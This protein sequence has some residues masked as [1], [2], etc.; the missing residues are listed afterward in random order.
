MVAVPTEHRNADNI[1]SI[2]SFPPNINLRPDI[3]HDILYLD[4]KG[5]IK[6]WCMLRRDEGHLVLSW[7]GTRQET[8]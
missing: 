4:I 7:M 1:E 8:V 5:I 2:Y 6:V 3:D